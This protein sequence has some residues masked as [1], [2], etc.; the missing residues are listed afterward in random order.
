MA[1]LVTRLILDDKQFNSNIANSKQQLKSYTD[2]T[3][4]LGSTFTK[5]AGGI[6]IAV[7]ASETFTK[8]LNSNKT[9]QDKFITLTEGMKE[10]VNDFF[11]SLM[12]GDWSVFDR[13]ITNAIKKGQTYITTLRNLKAALE[14]G[15]YTADELEAERD[16]AEV[17]FNKKG[18]STEERERA[19]TEF[20]KLSNEYINKLNETYNFSWKQ[21]QTAMGAKG[22]KFSSPEEIKKAYQQYLD[23]STMQ[24]A[25]L[26]QYKKDKAKLES[27]GTAIRGNAG[28]YD[29]YYRTPE[30]KAA[31]KAFD[32]NY[33]G[34]GYENLIRFQNLFTDKNSETI[35]S[36]ADNIVRFNERLA[37]ANKTLEDG[38]NDY[39]SLLSDE[40]ANTS[41]ILEDNKKKTFESN[42]L[43]YNIDN[44]TNEELKGLHDELVRKA[45][46]L[47]PVQIT[48][49]LVPIDEGNPDE[50][51]LPTE[52]KEIKLDSNNL[53][54]TVDSLNNVAT[55]LGAINQ[56]TN[57]GA[58]AWMSYLSTVITSVAT[59]IPA[60]EALTAVKQKEAV[61]NG[62][63]SATQTPVVGWLMAG[64]AVASVLAAMASIPK[65]A[66]GG[67]VG[68]TNFSG[69]NLLARVNSGEMILNGRQQRNL[70]SLL[71][72]NPNSIGNQVTFKIQ[73]KELVG[74]LNNYNNKQ[75]K[76]R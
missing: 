31:K 67:I 50:L 42:I 58:S 75:N 66:T 70:F 34:K 12:T 47:E 21:L 9:S 3:T 29:I 69:D 13:G 62:V 15:E 7:T 73:G 45:R 57:E 46:G 36:F 1:D 39:N 27:L 44:W 41:K 76:V 35:K 54:G 17:A 60:I 37:E 49:E 6:G 53:D 32:E 30:A 23:P 63:A 43:N 59:M 72:G 48:Y 26:E 71:N 25:M 65:F 40:A 5:L 68:G 4:K 56:L 8:A 61:V 52:N 16:K 10:T 11:S 64:A 55:I 22:V 24:Y 74:V 18:I 2:F 20:V 14:V 28:Q 38:K 51:P 33:G 19:Y